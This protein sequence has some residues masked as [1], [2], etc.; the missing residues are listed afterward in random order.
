[1]FLPPL[2]VYYNRIRSFIEI[3]LQPDELSAQS[4]QSKRFATNNQTKHEIHIGFG[5]A[6]VSVP[7]WMLCKIVVQSGES[8]A[9]MMIVILGMHSSLCTY[10]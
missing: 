9:V 8:I 10:I 5:F 3:P 2:L 6:A 1:M 4:I 7:G